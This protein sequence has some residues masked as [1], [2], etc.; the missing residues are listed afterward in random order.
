MTSIPESDRDKSRYRGDLLI[1][2]TVKKVAVEASLHAAQ[3]LLLDLCDFLSNDN[4][5]S[6]EQQMAIEHLHTRVRDYLMTSAWVLPPDHELLANLNLLDG[7]SPSR[8]EEVAL[9]VG[10]EPGVTSDGDPT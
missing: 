3:M 6:L 7:L 8:A 10:E 4:Y 2:C 9:G 1:E 5:T